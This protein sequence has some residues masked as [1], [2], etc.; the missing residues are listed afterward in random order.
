VHT[1]VPEAREDTRRDVQQTD[2]GA[3]PGDQDGNGL[4]ARTTEYAP[5]AA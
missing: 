4:G 2:D 5:R 1:A 3:R